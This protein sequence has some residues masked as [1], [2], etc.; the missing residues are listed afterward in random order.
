MFVRN[1]SIPLKL[2][3]DALHDESN[4][5]PRGESSADTEISPED[6]EWLCETLCALAKEERRAL[7][8]K[9]MRLTMDPLLVSDT[10]G[11]SDSGYCGDDDQD[12][13]M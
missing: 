10:D 3:K 9:R 2:S 12:D 7:R 13:D 5:S 4:P 8:Q 1:E 6:V 11:F